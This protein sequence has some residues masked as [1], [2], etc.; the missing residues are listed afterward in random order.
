MSA[1]HWLALMA[2]ITIVPFVIM[3]TRKPKLYDLT[4]EQRLLVLSF[5]DARPKPLIPICIKGIRPC[6]KTKEETP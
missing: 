4:R 5:H 6:Q 2:V 3:R 1:A